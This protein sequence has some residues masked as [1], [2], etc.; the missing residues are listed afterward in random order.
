M[1]CRFLQIVPPSG[2][3]MQVYSMQCLSAATKCG[4]S[5]RVLPEAVILKC[6]AAEPAI[7]AL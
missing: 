7:L 5:G 1:Q 4:E 6:P 3:G 2:H